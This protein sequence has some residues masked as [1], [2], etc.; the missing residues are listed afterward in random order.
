MRIRLGCISCVCLAALCPDASADGTAVVDLTGVRFQN[1]LNQ[2]RDSAPDTIDA[3]VRYTYVID[4]MVQGDGGLLEA[5]FPDPT[6]LADVLEYFQEGSSAFL[7]GTA[8]NPGG[9][10]P[11]GVLNERLE[12]STVILGITVNYGV[13]MSAG[14][15]ADGVAFFSA[16][17]VVLT[18]SFLVGSMVFT[19][20]SATIATAECLADFNGDCEVNTLDFIAYLNAFN[21][22]DPAADCDANGS[23]NTI[24]FLCYLNAFNAGC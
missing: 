5:L 16:T 2:S 8:C 17:D 13:T 12:G 4:G 6:P 11:A 24:D 9:G 1:G 20:G 23:I 7:A 19:S 15:R 21:A 14:I 18:P 22:T 10:L 3:S